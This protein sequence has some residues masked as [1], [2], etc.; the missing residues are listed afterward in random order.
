MLGPGRLAF[1]GAV[2]TTGLHAHAAVQLMVVT[3]G[4]V[5]LQDRHGELR[6]V[7]VAVIPSGACHAVHGSGA[8]AA[9]VYSDP[10]SSFGR[11]LQR[12]V[13]RGRRDHLDDWI[14]A[15]DSLG[16][17]ERALVHQHDAEQVLEGLL[18]DAGPD[19]LCHPAVRRAMD[20]TQRLLGGPVRLQDVA[21]A[22][23]LS[24]SRLGHL[25]AEE[26]GVPF[27]VYVRWA[28][29]RRAM[30]LVRVGATLTQAAHGAGF[31][32]SSHLT[33]VFREMF[34]L[35][36]STIVRSVRWDCA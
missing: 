3:A 28:R 27:P 11:A 8:T 6:A 18:A 21:E 25:F 20:R 13:G 1:T 15:A 9:C 36:P 2:G 16:L 33:R 24:P 17:A 31:T 7:R 5:M 26:L 32:D 23:G 22:V 10:G 29:L 4:R 14:C 35:A 34:G 12:R 30:E 19:A